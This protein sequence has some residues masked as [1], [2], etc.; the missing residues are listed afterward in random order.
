MSR[1]RQ[2]VA[3]AAVLL[4][5][6]LAFGQ[7][8]SI[9][10]D[11]E[12]A[13][14]T[15]RGR[16]L[17]EYDQAAWHSSDAAMATNP[18][19]ENLGRY[20]AQKTGAGWI[21][22]FGRLNE[23]RDAFQIATLATQGQTTQDFSVK[24]FDPP[25]KDTGF[26]LV[27]AKAIEVSLK[28]FQGANWP[29]NVAVLPAPAGQLYVYVY[30]AQKEN[31]VYPLGADARYLVSPDGAT[32]VEKRQLHKSIIPTGGPVPVG[33]TFVAGTHSHI[34]SNVPEDTDVFY[35]L[36][37]KPSMPEYIGTQIAI[38]VV[39]ADGTISVVERIKKHR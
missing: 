5:A 39:N 21:V 22:A 34:L 27:A 9:P 15:A 36:T 37:R 18:S 20:I 35:V 12:L 2:Y 19:K 13:Q 10:T 4:F 8:A 1:A 25:E 28:D 16:L 30:P 31:G 33:T 17:Y 24:K 23:A 14:I 29:Y 26:F 3:D 32:V 38:Y 11:N 6:S 7:A